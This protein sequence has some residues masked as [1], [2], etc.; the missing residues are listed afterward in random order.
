[1]HLTI[2]HD[3]TAMVTR[4]YRDPQHPDIAALAF[5]ERYENRDAIDE[6]TADGL[7][8]RHTKMFASS[9]GRLYWAHDRPHGSPA[10]QR[11]FF[12]EA[13]ALT[14][15]SRALFRGDTA[16]AARLNEVLSAVE[17]TLVSEQPEDLS[18]VDAYLAE[19]A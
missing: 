16:E 11:R 13:V 2:I 5:V 3:T 7:G 12:A 17:R 10:L 6:F 4:F 8:R 14:R 19:L 18:L 9:T 15:R 1:M